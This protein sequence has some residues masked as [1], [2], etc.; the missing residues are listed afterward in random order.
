MGDGPTKFQALRAV[1]RGTEQ[2]QA[3]EAQRQELKTECGPGHRMEMCL[4]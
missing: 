1:L 2:K 4:G 3:E